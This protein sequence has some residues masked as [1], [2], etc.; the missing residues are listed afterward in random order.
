MGMG[1]I[2]QVDLVQPS[3]RTNGF[4]VP[5]H[6]LYLASVR[7][8]KYLRDLNLVSRPQ[9]IAIRIVEPPD[10]FHPGNESYVFSD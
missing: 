7:V 8:F 4:L 9:V 2:G 6:F 5:T 10:R 3:P 1:H